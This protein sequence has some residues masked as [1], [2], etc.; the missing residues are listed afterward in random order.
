[1]WM[2][3]RKNQCKEWLHEGKNV[4]AAALAARTKAS[5]EVNRGDHGLLGFLDGSKCYERVGH[6]LA[7]HDA[8]QPGLAARVANMVFDIYRTPR[9]EFVHSI[10]PVGQHSRHNQ[11]LDD[12][13][14]VVETHRRCIVDRVHERMR[15][16]NEAT[17]AERMRMHANPAKSEAIGQCANSQIHT[18]KKQAV[19]SVTSIFITGGDGGSSVLLYNIRSETRPLT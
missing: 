7:G 5:I 18:L 8:L 4:G 16:T 15:H 12:T 9:N 3:I 13:A 6:A 11:M 19:K 10:R 1:M 14:D 17:L 2:A